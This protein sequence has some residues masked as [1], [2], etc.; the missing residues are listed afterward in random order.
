MSLQENLELNKIVLESNKEQL[1][2][3]DPKELQ[4]AKHIEIPYGFEKRNIFDN[5]IES[6]LLKSF[7]YLDFASECWMAFIIWSILP[8]TFRDL[9]FF[10]LSTGGFSLNLLYLLIMLIPLVMICIPCVPF[11]LHSFYRAVIIIC[12]IASFNPNII[13]RIILLGIAS[14]FG[15]MYFSFMSVHSSKAIRERF[16]NATPVGLLI[17]QTTLFGAGMNVF[18]YR[19]NTSVICGVLSVIAFIILLFI[20]IF[21]YLN[22]NLLIEIDGEE[23]SEIKTTPRWF[24]IIRIIFGILLCFSAATLMF[25][26]ILFVQ[27]PAVIPQYIGLS[28]YP[29]GIFPILALSIGI[30]IDHFHITTTSLWWLFSF[31]S[32]IIYTFV[33]NEISFY[34]G[35]IFLVTVPGLWKALIESIAMNNLLFPF[36]VTTVLIIYSVFANASVYFQVGFLPGLGI[37]YGSRNWLSYFVHIFLFF[38]YCVGFTFRFIMNKKEDWN[39]PLWIIYPLQQKSYETLRN[40][41]FLVKLPKREKVTIVLLIFIVIVIPSIIYQSSFKIVS[42]GA[43]NRLRVMTYNIFQG[44]DIYGNSNAEKISNLINQNSPNIIGFQ[45]SDTTRIFNNNENIIEFISKHSSMD[46]YLGLPSQDD[47]IGAALSTTLRIKTIQSQVLPQIEGSNSPQRPFI[48]STIDVG[49][50]DLN[51]LNCYIDF[52]SDNQSSSQ[53]Q[54]VINTANTLQGPLILVGGFN[55]GPN[56]TQIQMILNAGYQSAYSDTHNGTNDITWISVS[57]RNITDKLDYIFYRN[58]TILKSWI[59]QIDYSDHFPI[60]AEFK[61]N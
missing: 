43:P 27:S 5:N 46:Y 51:F 21:Y 41:L 28:S 19:W 33:S 16:I 45:E 12:L 10:T 2:H 7:R 61:I 13:A 57:N 23:I 36:S 6:Y 14:S 52:S 31:I 44:F 60:F 3:E 32:L 53:I 47:S 1:T 9:Y 59:L 25:L 18:W 39:I 29:F 58:I 34:F 55:Y 42:S 56:T 8:K 30:L 11:V 48:I 20:E 40:T 37:V 22:P 4:E 24:L 15:Y 38:P 49:G 26:M 54:Y 35:M 50:I 17:S